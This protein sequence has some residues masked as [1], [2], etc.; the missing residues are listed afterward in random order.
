MNIL[1]NIPLCF[2]LL[3]V[4]PALFSCGETAPAH[5][6]RSLDSLNRRAYDYR[7]KDLDSSYA[8]ASRAYRE[9]RFYS[10]G[11]AEAS[12]NLAFCA[13]MRMD[14]DGAE[15][16]YKEVPGITPNELERLI[17]DIGLMRIYQRT[18]LNKEYYDARNSALR[19]MKRINEDIS[20]FVEPHEL[21]RLN[22]AFSEFR[23]VSA[24][25]YSYLRQRAEAMASLAQVKVDSALEADTSQYLS[26][27][28]VRGA[29]GLIKAENS[30]ERKV[31]EFDYLF[32]CW[33]ISLSGSFLYFEANA[34]QSISELLIDPA[35]FNLLYE[36]RVR[37]LRLLN[38]EGVPD[39]LLSLHLA[40][41]ALQ[42]FE[43]YGDVYRTAGAYRTLGTYY[44]RHGRFEEA[45]SALTVALGYVNK[46]HEQYYHCLDTADRLKPFVA[47]DS[48]FNELAWMKQGDIRTVPEWIAGI[49]E[50]L[51]VAYAGLGRKIPSDYNR[52]IY[53]DILDHTRQDKELESRYMALEKESRQLTLLMGIV[54]AGILFMVVLFVILNARWKVRNRSYVD[55][56]KLTLDVC[57]KVTASIPADATGT[58]EIVDS[59]K[60]TVSED[61]RQLFGTVKMSICVAGEACTEPE[62]HTDVP[63]SRYDLS[64]PDQ[65]EPVGKLLLYTGR[66]LT[67]DE[68]ALVRVI[69]PYIAWTIDNGLKIIALGDTR[70]HLDKQ[71]YVYEQHL[72][73]NK[74][75]NLVKKSCLAIVAGIRPYMD[76]AVNEVEKIK[77][78]VLQSRADDRATDPGLLGSRFRYLGELV[79]KINEYNDIL[80]LWIK[81]KPGSLSL[82]I[83]NFALD[84]LFG[85][86]A[87]GRKTFDMKRLEFTVQP[88]DAI[89]K[90]DKAL[91]LFMINTL[92][93][94]ARK[95]TPEG[96]K[97][98]LYAC[99]SGDYV[100]ISVVDTGRGLSPEDVSKIV[101]EKIY[102]SRQIGMHG[103]EGSEELAENKGSGFGLMNC[104]GI[105]E[106]YR[107]TNE[108]F[109]V[110]T[111]GIESVQGR[112]SRFYFR[113]PK[114]VRK[115]LPVLMLL[116]A[117]TLHA[118][119]GNPVPVSKNLEYEELLIEASHFADTVYF[120]NVDEN[121]ALALQYA[122]S[123]LNRLNRHY[124]RYSMH[125]EVF[126]E[127]K[128][129]GPAAESEWWNKGFE[130]DYY[131]ILDIRNE[132]AVAYLALRDL[133]GYTY[134][135]EA[136]TTL[137]KLAGEDHSLES[138]CR[139]L[140][141]SSNNKAVGL[142]LCVLLLLLLL[143]G[144]YL[145]YFRR[146]LMNRL[147]LEQ[148]LEINRQ[149]F[150][151]SDHYSHEPYDPLAV[152]SQIVH[153]AFDAVNELL[154][155]DVFGI[156][157]FDEETHRLNFVFAPSAGEEEKLVPL[158]RECFARR[159]GVSAPDASVQCL[160]LLVDTAGKARCVGV[161]AILKRTGNE[162]ETSRLL[163]ELVAR[164]VAIV[165]FNATVRLAE[166]YRDI[167]TAE[168]EVR[169]VSRE[170]GL[171][172]VQN[173][174]LDNCLSTIKH[175]TIYYPSKIRQILEKSNPEDPGRIPGEVE[176]ISELIDYY[177]DIFTILSS[178]ASRQLEEVVFRRSAVS[179]D[180]LAA[181][182]VKYLKKAGR[183]SRSDLRLEI[184]SSG[185]YVLADRVLLY[186]LLENLIDEAVSHASDGVLKLEAEPDGAFVRF[187]FTDLRREKPVGELNELFY[188]DL[189]KMRVDEAGR[190]SGTEYLVCKQIIR[191]HDEF[192][193]RRGCRINA[194]PA[195]GGGFTVYF[196]LPWKKDNEL[197]N[198]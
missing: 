152:P 150:A 66:Q 117:G 173:M 22:Y 72:A 68:V 143:A 177:K 168:D 27:Y 103:K 159:T 184:A 108:V 110:C 169:R 14:F 7:Y 180:E 73:E 135:N 192:A 162:L 47:R 194:E 181:H 61:F 44:N 9:A 85:V 196:T 33:R 119:P 1:R 75:Q 87:K 190:L 185:L 3:L 24:V 96:G 175:E 92:T 114:G 5:E 167:E 35:T 158:M 186:F 198:E 130:S 129:S 133:D 81:M 49:R 141:H 18:S 15:R 62:E 197:S 36:R 118:A 104:K 43:K 53:L 31:Q 136:Y 46:H 120:C 102:D 84:E 160:P 11:K 153:E 10:Q 113:L 2:L 89:V 174:V 164:Y 54:I 147:N 13:F 154:T 131:V 98:S 55:R 74:R 172:H 140:Q 128:G 34:L 157:V 189:S 32:Y 79:A 121:Y 80:A 90:A 77:K 86:I 23:I 127:L 4:L 95:Y 134:N 111:F 91:T 188:P 42:R 182:A 56:L 17:A 146:R 170:E 45:L 178:C 161:L 124:E 12:N 106:K 20:V 144:Y 71:R 50:Q 25:Y 58:K 37:A 176:T 65:P 148:V 76:R 78:L 26:Y 145:L 171:I 97:V 41:G 48:V 52:N 163:F 187:R 132:A 122:D 70:R 51:S 63:V 8:A 142:T 88:S 137:Y 107:K 59:V 29:A 57:R 64:I 93:E 101:S 179:C 82:N 115:V 60:S 156:G 165:V 21:L 191:D 112:G 166:K 69:T 126:L 116:C 99:E 40:Q 16:L 38:P 30:Q 138:F 183:K 139:D 151:V 67:K 155:V 149:I 100:E 123:A 6:I 125:P 83:E 28:Y 105:I 109:R 19:R 39:S 94:N 195:P 193:G